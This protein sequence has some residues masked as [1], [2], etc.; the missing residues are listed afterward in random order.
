MLS[1]RITL[2]VLGLGSFLLNQAGMEFFLL[3]WVDNWGLTT[4]NAIRFGV[5]LIGVVMVAVSMLKSK[6]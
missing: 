4:G 2:I 6:K 3:A 5:A 1:W